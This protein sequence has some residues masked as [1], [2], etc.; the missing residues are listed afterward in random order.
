MSGQESKYPSSRIR[1]RFQDC[2][3]F[4]HLNN[5]R[6]IDYFLN[7][8]EEHLSDFHGFDIYERQKS[9]GTNWVVLR[10]QI[11]YLQP[12]VFREWVVIRT[13]LR[14]LTTTTLLMEGLM[15]GHD[16]RTLKSVIWTEF[17]HFD[18]NRARPI[19]HSSELM[20]FFG[21]IAVLE[22]GRAPGDFQERVKELKAGFEEIRQ[23]V[24]GRPHGKEVPIGRAIPNI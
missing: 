12:A 22:D 23:E 6:Y 2:D 5:A 16:Q 15:L 8:R 9:T 21:R 19:G 1:I 4:G 17:R 13:C 11:A 3:P 10:H 14:R 7:A 18:L 20:D 24:R